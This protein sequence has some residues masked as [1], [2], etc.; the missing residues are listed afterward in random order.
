MRRALPAEIVCCV[1]GRA[2]HVPQRLNRDLAAQ[3]GGLPLDRPGHP[4]RAQ[5]SLYPI[6]PELRA[7][8]SSV[9]TVSGSVVPAHAGCRPRQ[10][11]PMRAAIPAP[12]GGPRRR[13]TPDEEFRTPARFDREDVVIQ[14]LNP[15]R[16]S[17]RRALAALMRMRRIIWAESA[18]KCSRRHVRPGLCERGMRPAGSSSPAGSSLSMYSTSAFSNGR[19]GAGGNSNRK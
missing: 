18:K 15:P 6:R 1:G 4:T 13:R 5:E 7:D 14:L 17:A 11:H 19:W 10:L 12:D 16:F 3:G 9:S 2:G 8:R